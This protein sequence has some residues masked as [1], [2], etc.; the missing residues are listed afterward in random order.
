MPQIS[1]FYGISIYMYINDHQPPH[2]HVKYNDYEAFV[3]ID[4]G[5]VKGELPR[6]VI[7]LVFEWLDAHKEE[8]MDNWKRLQNYESPIKIKPLD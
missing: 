1:E 3:N 7:N 6:R 5:V 8:L 4:N 2:F